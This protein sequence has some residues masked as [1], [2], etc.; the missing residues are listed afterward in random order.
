[1]SIHEYISQQTYITI[2]FNSLEIPYQ[3]CIFM[4]FTEEGIY[5]KCIQMNISV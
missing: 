1:M 4:S 3:Y 2:F 5:I